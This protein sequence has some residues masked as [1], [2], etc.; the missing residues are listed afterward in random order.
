MVFEADLSVTN[1][2]PTSIELCMGWF[3]GFFIVSK[4]SGEVKLVGK[5]KQDQT[6][7]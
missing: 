3:Q 2:S 6:F 7:S 1:P 4:G 5:G